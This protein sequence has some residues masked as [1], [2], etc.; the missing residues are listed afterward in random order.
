MHLLHPVTV[1]FFRGVDDDFLNKL[2]DH[3]RG[4]LREVGVL[5]CQLQKQ[6]HT[7]GILCESGQLFFRFCDRGLQRFLLGFV[8]CQQT[9]KALIGN[10][11][12]SKGF[13]ELF[14]DGVQLG[15]TLFVF[16]QLSLGILGR[17]CLSK[18]GGGAYLLQKSVSV[19][20]GKG[21]SSPDGFQNQLPQRFGAD[22][23]STASGGALLTCQLVCGAFKRIV[24]IW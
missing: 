8:I 23:M 2:V 6:L 7:G 21:A 5:P 16:A 11:P 22:M 20:D 10:A 18:L 19:G 17:L 4:Q 3:G 13:I 15:N 1:N 24:G 12:D 9:V 14:D